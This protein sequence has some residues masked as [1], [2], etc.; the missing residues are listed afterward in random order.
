MFLLVVEDDALATFMTDQRV[1]DGSVQRL[2]MKIHRSYVEYILNPFTPLSA[3]GPIESIRFQQQV[4][5]CITSY[6]RTLL[7]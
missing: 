1:I 3:T 2:L 6:N 7:R 5:E 4:D